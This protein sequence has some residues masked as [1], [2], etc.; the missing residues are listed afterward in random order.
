M[1]GQSV[2]QFL[3]QSSVYSHV[4]NHYSVMFQYETG[5]T[6][7]IRLEIWCD[8]LK[9]HIISLCGAMVHLY[10]LN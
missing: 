8:I 3:S 5:H 6:R 4:I 9:L 7:L 2:S 1:C 10:Y